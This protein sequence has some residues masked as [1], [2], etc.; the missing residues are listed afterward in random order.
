MLHLLMP[1]PL[2]HLP[3]HLVGED[4]PRCIPLNIETRCHLPHLEATTHL[5]LGQIPNALSVQHQKMYQ[6]T[7]EQGWIAFVASHWAQEEDIPL[8]LHCA[9]HLFRSGSNLLHV[10]QKYISQLM[11][12]NLTC[13]VHLYQPN[14]L[15]LNLSVLVTL[16]SVMGMS[17]NCRLSL[18]SCLLH[19]WHPSLPLPVAAPDNGMQVDTGPCSV[20]PSS[21]PKPVD[22]LLPLR[23][24]H[25]RSNSGGTHPTRGT[26]SP[27][28]SCH[29]QEKV[30]S[31]AW[32]THHIVLH[33]HMDTL[34]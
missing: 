22:T 7:S 25:L 11:S 3:F 17:I 31:S 27:T 33:R 20:S 24:S 32:L 18:L 29:S 2:S 6:K 30:V 5:L 9:N 10:H 26:I 14:F 21:R 15:I 16:A 19:Q 13:K 4:Y 34:L 28:S 1:L 12:S 8:S 23:T